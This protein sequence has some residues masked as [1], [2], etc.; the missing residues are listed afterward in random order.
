MEIML[1]QNCQEDLITN[2]NFQ[3]NKEGQGKISIAASI[4]FL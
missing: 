2:Y 1:E 4:P 3:G